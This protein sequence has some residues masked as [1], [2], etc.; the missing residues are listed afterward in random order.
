MRMTRFS[1]PTPPPGLGAFLLRIA[2]ALNAVAA[3][4]APVGCGHKF[5][6]R[7]LRGAK[8]M[9]REVLREVLSIR[10]SSSAVRTSRS[11]TRSWKCCASEGSSSICA[12]SRGAQDLEAEHAVAGDDGRAVCSCSIS[13]AISPTSEPGTTS[14]ASPPSGTGHALRRSR[15]DQ[16]GAVAGLP[17]LG[18]DVARPIS[19][20][21]GRLRDLRELGAASARRKSEGATAAP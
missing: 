14:L 11:V 17:C 5:R 8:P 1:R 16:V 20:P 10:R 12:C 2:M 7:R 3:S 13:M 6:R 18:D 15:H 4:V 19:Q 9:R 21:L